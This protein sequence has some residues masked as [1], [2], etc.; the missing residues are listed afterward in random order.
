MGTAAGDGEVVAADCDG[1]PVDL[2]QTHHV[3]AGGE[4]DE[5]AS[6]VVVGRAHEGAGLDEA[7]GVDH[8]LDAFADG[9][10]AAGVLA[11]DS[12]GAAHLAPELADVGDV[13]DGALPGHAGLPALAVRI[14]GHGGGSSAVSRTLRDRSRW[15]TASARG[16]GVW[17]GNER[18]QVVSQGGVSEHDRALR[19]PKARVEPRQFCHGS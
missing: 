6:L 13:L 15:R 8:L 4:A 5:V 17:T 12:F 18:L 9:V 1:A 3:G 14:D 10:A 2:G 7:A 11:G 19:R 16:S